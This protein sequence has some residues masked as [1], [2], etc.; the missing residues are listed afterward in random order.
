MFCF[1]RGFYKE[2]PTGEVDK[3]KML[4][5]YRLLLPPGNARVFVEQLFGLFDTDKGGTID[6]K[7][8]FSKTTS[9]ITIPNL[10]TLLFSAFKNSGNSEAA[11]EANFG[12][13]SVPSVQ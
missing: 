10:R 12:T 1:S 5:M 13:E 7:V 3:Q 6:F 4:D 9:K 2:C 8:K 11:L